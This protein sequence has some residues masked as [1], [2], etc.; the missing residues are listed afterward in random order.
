M[1]NSNKQDEVIKRYQS[2]L[3]IYSFYIDVKNDTITNL[4][5]NS[6]P[7]N[8]FKNRFTSKEF[9][10]SLIHPDD[11]IEFELTLQKIQK[12]TLKIWVRLRILT[13]NKEYHIFKINLFKEDNSKNYFCV[14]QDIEEDFNQLSISLN[15][16]IKNRYS[17]LE[18]T[19]EN[20][21]V[22]YF[23]L[24]YLNNTLNLSN[25][26]QR[27]LSL[28]KKVT[29]YRNFILN[30]DL[31]HPDDL[32]LYQ[33]ISYNILN[34]KI[35]KKSFEVRI[36]IEDSY[37]WHR[38][39]ISVNERKNGF[40]T[41]VIG[42]I[43]NI[44]REIRT[45]YKYNLRMNDLNKFSSNYVANIVIDL[46]TEFIISLNS[47]IFEVEKDN[48]KISLKNYLL[49]IEKDFFKRDDFD[50]ICDFF[51]INNLRKLKNESQP[52][53]YQRSN[54]KEIGIW[55][56]NHISYVL[57]PFNGKPIAIVECYDINK[58]EE[59]RNLF[60]SIIEKQNEVVIR[61]YR[62]SRQVYVY[63]KEGNKIGLNTGLNTVSFEQFDKFNQV[64]QNNFIFLNYN[65]ILNNLENI[66]KSLEINN[67]YSYFFEMK[68]L[69]N[70]YFRLN[71]FLCDENIL[72]IYVDE[73]TEVFKHEKIINQALK[74]AISK[75]Q[76]S[77]LEEIKNNLK[78]IKISAEYLLALLNDALE[79]Q[80]SEHKKLIAKPVIHDSYEFITTTAKIIELKAK[81]KNI[82]FNYYY[83][84]DLNY[85]YT[86]FDIVRAR[87][88]LLN[89][90]NNSVKYTKENGQINWNIDGYYLKGR[91]HVTHTIK[92]SG[93]GMSEEFQKIM[94]DKFSRE[95]NS[96]I[97]ASE[98]SGL[99]LSI[100]KNI[101][102]S[103][104]GT[105]DCQSKL[106]K[107]TITTIKLNFPVASDEEI[108]K[109]TQ[110]KKNHLNNANYQGKEVL[111]VEDIKINAEIIKKLLKD[112]EVDSKWVDNGQK[113]VNLVRK[114]QFDLVIMDI[115]MPVLN[116]IE[117]TKQ[118]RSFNQE[119]PIIAL[120][121]NA[122]PLDIK[123]SL[124]AGMNSHLS[125]PIDRNIFY[126]VIKSYLINK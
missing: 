2:D 23:E 105:I 41:K 75:A 1:T 43:T 69:K 94:Y 125:K 73:V 89:I 126:Q 63:G 21:G 6:S 12:E 60:K 14:L 120:S 81:E 19:L 123:E 29:N 25:N 20:S 88:V 48:S 117:A 83:N 98:G 61:A 11:F 93:V 36:K 118:I 114:Q 27:S 54:G 55:Y 116:G 58:L 68:K 15:N 50:L 90:L 17:S 56:E 78:S 13:L 5:N 76:A 121:A 101:V 38:I 8:S 82:K 109:F 52:I 22:N 62:D 113:A 9:S 107:G 119:L 111:I 10:K 115:R 18:E 86:D 70:F 103:W 16:N 84:L 106:G 46:D 96:L 124:N 40:P 79:I 37:R 4:E 49:S 45:Q 95:D 26:T 72:L 80:N 71:Y 100:T 74:T 47:N 53:K 42:T 110:K 28:P 85:R 91:I 32:S 66:F 108:K 57:D 39:S 3:K 92:D 112:I 64:N 59:E 34:G 33:N 99:G 7:F 122:N 102:E 67:S 97:S 44:E 87:Q 24:D 65:P 51:D 31:I 104:G 30:S 77:N 35:A